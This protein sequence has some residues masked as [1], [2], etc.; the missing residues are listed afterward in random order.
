MGNPA[1]FHR[2]GEYSDDADTQCHDHSSYCQRRCADEALS[3]R[4]SGERCGGGDQ[5]VSPGI[6]RK[7]YDGRGGRGD[8]RAYEA[9]GDRG[10]RFGCADGCLYS[11]GK[12][13]IG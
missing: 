11:G 9:G 10:N 13:R 2:A 12:D 7:P 4:K 6:S 5:K 1:D 8:G 3:Y